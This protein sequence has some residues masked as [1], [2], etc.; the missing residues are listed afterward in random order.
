MAQEQLFTTSLIKKALE[1]KAEIKDLQ[2]R[3]SVGE[4]EAL[5]KYRCENADKYVRLESARKEFV[6]VLNE[7]VAKKQMVDGF[8]R[9]VNKA[10]A[11][12]VVNIERFR[13][14]FPETFFQIA[15]IPVTK[16]EA[17]VGKAQLV[18][19][20]DISFGEAM[21]DVEYEKPK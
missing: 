21:W 14:A 7:C 12:R 15:T 6:S 2:D 5:E 1:I 3:I 20:C 10:R 8:Y 18:P 4:R 19:L 13:T 9:V 16:A 17:I 11:T